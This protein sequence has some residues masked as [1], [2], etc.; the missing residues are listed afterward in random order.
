MW[1][2]EA[3]RPEALDALV[4]AAA[5]QGVLFKRGAYQFGA[6][7]HESGAEEELAQ[8]LPE[9]VAAA[10]AMLGALPGSPDEGGA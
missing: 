1:R 7:A 3:D 6:V 9:A 10:E 2:L 4:A 5:R 8:A